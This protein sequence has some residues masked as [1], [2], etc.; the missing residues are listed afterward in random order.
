MKP[1]TVESPQVPV[2]EPIEILGEHWRK[3]MAPASYSIDFQLE[4]L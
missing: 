1:P 3:F 2:A 4:T